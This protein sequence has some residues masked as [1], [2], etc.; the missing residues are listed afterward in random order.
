M[1][2]VL[3]VCVCVRERVCFAVSLAEASAYRAFFGLDASHQMSI[4]LPQF[5]VGVGGTPYPYYRMM[6]LADVQHMGALL[7]AQ[8]SAM[9]GFPLIT[10]CPVLKWCDY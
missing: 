8:H 9:G 1:V 7:L 4:S 3:C 10:G 6:T 2:T 5:A